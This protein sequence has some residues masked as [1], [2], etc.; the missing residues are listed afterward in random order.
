M[1][2]DFFISHAGA[3]VASAEALFDVLKSSSRVFVDSHSLRPGDNW[4]QELAAAQ[5]ASQITLV[6]ASSQTEKAYY[7]GEEIARAINMSREEG[8]SHR[9]IPIYLDD[10]KAQVP[11]GLQVLQCISVSPSHDLSKIGTDL[12]QLLRELSPELKLV[13]HP[14]SKDKDRGEL[15]PCTFTLNSKYKLDPYSRWKNLADVLVN[16][17]NPLGTR[18]VFMVPSGAAPEEYHYTDWWL[19]SPQLLA[20]KRGITEQFVKDNLGVELTGAWYPMRRNNIDYTTV[21][22]SRYD[23]ALSTTSGH[24]GA[25]TAT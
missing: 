19:K 14:A 7:Q 10:V 6:L 23:K 4:P 11:F 5:G 20:E 16:F 8:S 25:P 2:W 15:S 17:R 21:Y 12:L 13:W 24:T 22:C 18:Y 9:V 1:K 3:D